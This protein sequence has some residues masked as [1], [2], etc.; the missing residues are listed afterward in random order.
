MYTR[1]HTAGLASAQPLEIDS[2]HFAN[3]CKCM[4]KCLTVGQGSGTITIET[5]P[6][7]GRY[8]ERRNGE[9][10]Q[11]SWLDATPEE[12]LQHGVSIRCAPRG[13]KTSGSVFEVSQRSTRNVT[14]SLYGLLQK[15]NYAQIGV[16]TI[17][18]LSV[19]RCDLGK[20]GTLA[21][22]AVEPRYFYAH[23][24]KFVWQFASF[25]NSTMGY[26]VAVGGNLS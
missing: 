20:I 12:A 6:N 14:R 4:I 5:L 16:A 23:F 8:D 2:R 9:H 21:Q 25:V 18:I 11:R 15:K 1:P 26:G 19:A 10:H 24:S 3:I 13:R 17:D 7:T 22:A